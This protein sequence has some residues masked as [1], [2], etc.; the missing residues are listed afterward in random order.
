MRQAFQWL[1]NKGIFPDKGE[2]SM[3]RRLMRAASLWK[4]RHT[5]SKVLNS[6][7][8]AALRIL[9]RRDIH[10]LY[11]PHPVKMHILP[12]NLTTLVR[13]F[14]KLPMK[15]VL[16]AEHTLIWEIAPGR[17]VKTLTN[18]GL[19]LMIME[20]I[21]IQQ[22]Y[23]TQYEG[24]RVLDVGGYIGLS[25]V[26]FALKGA[27]A[28]A[29]IEPYPPSAERILENLRMAGFEDKVRLFK[30]GL[31]GKAG[32]GTLAVA[33]S[34]TQS[35]TLQDVGRS[36]APAEFDK[37]I[38][39][40]V[41]TI[42]DFL[43]ELGWDTIDVVKLDC[44][45]CEYALFATASDDTLRKVKAWVMEFHDGAERI[46][47]RLRPLGYVIYYEE[48]PDKMGNLYAW[49]K[50]FTPPWWEQLPDSYRKKA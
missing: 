14:D 46:L 2:Q 9:L 17:Y 50:D 11:L 25:S 48:R 47:N 40:P 20:E 38:Q 31:S 3:G 41:L 5:A 16:P 19:E 4:N 8:V 43:R 22:Q 37:A 42:E 24:L 10:T 30:A 7:K 27:E 45:G 12:Y 35:N 1:Q 28:V 6:W 34:D 32:T 33:S 21:F 44:E 13:I 49:Q 23:G 29:C 15:Q 26:F 36:S 39:V 18:Q